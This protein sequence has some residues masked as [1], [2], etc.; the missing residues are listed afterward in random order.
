MKIIGGRPRNVKNIGCA[1][2]GPILLDPKETKILLKRKMYMY[3]C[4]ND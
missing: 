1:K 2:K 4:K 3:T